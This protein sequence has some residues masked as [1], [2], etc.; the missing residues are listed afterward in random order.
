[1][2]GDGNHKNA[3]AIDTKNNVVGKPLDPRLPVNLI[4]LREPVWILRH[5]GQRFNRR[6]HETDGSGLASFAIP[7]KGSVKVCLGIAEKR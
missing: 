6:F 3:I 4:K 2:V 5:R 1:V 7:T